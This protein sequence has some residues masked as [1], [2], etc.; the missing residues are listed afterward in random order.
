MAASPRVKVKVVD[1]AGTLIK[2]V[3]VRIEGAAG[4]ASGRSSR[5]GWEKQDEGGFELD[6][7][8]GDVT[9]HFAGK[10][11]EWNATSSISTKGGKVYTLPDLVLAAKGT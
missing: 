10:G 7:P 5:G 6:V 3:F 11:T 1:S 2:D 9:I 4:E 8:L